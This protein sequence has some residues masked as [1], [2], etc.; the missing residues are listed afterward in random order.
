M[1][2]IREYESGLARRLLAGLAER[3]RF[4][5]W[6]T[7]K[8]DRWPGGADHGAD[9]RGRTPRQTAE[10]LAER[11]IYSWAGDMYALELSERLGREANGAF[12]RLGLAE[13]NTAEEVDR[14]LAAL[15]EL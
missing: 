12:L 9:G 5:V 10:H 2:A 3:P 13:S 1:N 8:P 11:E 6:G 14:T 4:R 15:D 7:V